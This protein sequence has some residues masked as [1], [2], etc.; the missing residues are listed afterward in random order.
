MAAVVAATAQQSATERDTVM[1][2]NVLVV[3]AISPKTQAAVTGVVKG[4]E[5]AFNTKDA[6]ALGARF[7]EHASWTN[8]MGRRLDGR[9]AIVAF[10][11]PAMEG[12]LRDSFARYEVRKM[13]ETGPGVIVVNVIQ[14]PTDS[15][16][17]PVP[18]PQGVALYVITGQGEDWLIAAGQN[19]AVETSPAA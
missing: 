1:S 11:G 3:G 18:G 15:A 4:L 14:T 5:R 7:T 9:E 8:A 12:F 10:S 13:L 19:M 2:S 6:V 16:G 17:E